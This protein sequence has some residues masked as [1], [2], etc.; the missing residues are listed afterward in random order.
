MPEWQRSLSP[1][2]GGGERALTP[3]ETF[4]FPLT[5]GLGSSLTC[6]LQ[7]GRRRS[8]QGERCAVTATG[9]GSMSARPSM[10][11]A[12]RGCIRL[13]AFQRS[14]PTPGAVGRL[15]ALVDP[16]IRLGYEP[17]VDL[18]EQGT[19]PLILLTNDDGIAS[20]GCTPWRE[21]SRSRDVIVVAPRHQ[22]S[23]TGRALAHPPLRPRD[24]D[25]WPPC[26]PYWWRRPQPL[27]FGRVTLAAQ[28]PVT[29]L[30]AGINYGENV[31]I[32]VTASGTV[33]CAIGP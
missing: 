5:S 4:S 18:T 6:E 24:T 20:P 7:Q 19:R 12:T 32:G 2:T 16:R 13:E 15:S 23:S 9:G 30:I 17:L 14:N 28:R 33:G 8:R 26:H 22:Q 1:G 31:G 11:G 10:T 21:P 29:L 3:I 27:R 25:G